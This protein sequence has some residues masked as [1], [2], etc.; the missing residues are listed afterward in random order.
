VEEE[1]ARR[2]DFYLTT[3]NNLKR[4]TSMNMVE[5]K[6]AIPGSKKLPTHALDCAASG[7]GSVK[8]NNKK[9]IV[10]KKE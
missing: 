6:H 3:H 1:S 4:Q 8:F 7:I 9:S 2:K 5:F 10:G